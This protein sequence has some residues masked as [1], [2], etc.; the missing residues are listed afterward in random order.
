MLLS[1][2]EALGCFV[3][4]RVEEAGVRALGLPC[5]SEYEYSMTGPQGS[6]DTGLGFLTS[7]VEKPVCSPTYL[8]VAMGIGVQVHQWVEGLHRTC[9]KAEVPAEAGCGMSVDRLF[10]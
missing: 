10:D 5:G 2:L 7:V 3:S 4:G 6:W 8:G 1:K 9:A